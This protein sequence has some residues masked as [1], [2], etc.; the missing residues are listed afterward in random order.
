MAWDP[1]IEEVISLGKEEERSESESW[2][3]EGPKI[4]CQLLE[5]PKRGLCICVHVCVYLWVYT[6]VHI[7]RCEATWVRKTLGPIL[8]SLTLILHLKASYWMNVHPGECL[9]LIV[10]GGWT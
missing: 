3:L 9:F 4:L 7:S 2:L 5:R 6:R 8:G 1:E 10:A